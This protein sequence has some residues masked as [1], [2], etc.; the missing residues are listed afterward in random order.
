MK[1]REVLSLLGLALLNQVHAAS[2]VVALDL[3]CVKIC[4]SVVETTQVRGAGNLHNSVIFNL[5]VFI[6][7]LC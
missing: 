7:T 5:P 3:V 2:L 6:I 4:W 1:K